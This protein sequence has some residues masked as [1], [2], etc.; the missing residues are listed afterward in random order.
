[1]ISA[2]ILVFG[3][4]S[5]ALADDGF[6]SDKMA[7]ALG[8]SIGAY[9]DC[10]SLWKSSSSSSL[11]EKFNFKVDDKFVSAVLQPHPDPNSNAIVLAVRGTNNNIQLVSE[12]NSYLV[13]LPKQFNLP[14]INSSALVLEYFADAA[15]GLWSQIKPRIASRANSEILVA[16]HS[17]GGAVGALL[18]L[19]IATEFKNLTLDF[20][21]FGEPRVGDVAFSKMFD[22]WVP[23]SW[24]VVHFD[25]IVPHIPP[26]MK[27]IL[28]PLS[29]MNVGLGKYHHGTEVWFQKDDGVYNLKENKF[30]SLQTNYKICTGV[31]IDE[32]KSCA[33]SLGLQVGIGNHLTYFGTRLNSAGF[34]FC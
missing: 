18:A 29:C 33:N 19:R 7:T 2:G 6:D 31:P 25:D 5:G 16:G 21:S 13:K 24:R 8:A 14:G 10:G 30:D 3:L 17:L 34:D 11:V 23:S 26:C 4:I 1:M 22:H 32:D 20:Y 27:S 15:D 28:D 12:I 9:S